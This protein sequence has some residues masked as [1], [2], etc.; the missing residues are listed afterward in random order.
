MKINN[1]LL[2]LMM[3]IMLK[4]TLFDGQGLIESSICPK[5][6][7]GYLLLRQHMCKVACFKSNIQLF[8]KDYYGDKYEIAQVKDMFGNEHY[9]K[10]IKVITTNNA[11]KWLK[12][13]QINYD[14]WC[15]KVNECNNLFGIVKTAHKSKLGDVQ[16]MSYQMVNS[17][18]LDAMDSVIKVSKEYIESL[19]CNNEIFIEYLKNN[20]NFS[21]DYEVLVALCEQ[22]WD[23][24][25]SEYFRERKKK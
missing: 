8:F 15:K 11:M 13:P 9:V 25:R 6:T 20:S 12:F 18:D 23:F 3:S 7:S 5:Y 4:N 19:K 1:V 24:T 17:L 14:Y 16:K 22:N 21:N 2:N 10:D